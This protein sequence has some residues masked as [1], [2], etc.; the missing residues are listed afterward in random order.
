MLCQKAKLTELK[1]FTT[2]KFYITIHHLET[3]FIQ[4]G[5]IDI[6]IL[7]YSFVHIS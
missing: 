5:F 2:H 4:Q 6:I 7:T 1:F 3:K